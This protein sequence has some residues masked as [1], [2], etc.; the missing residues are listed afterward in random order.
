MLFRSVQGIWDEEDEFLKEAVV[1]WRILPKEV[2][3]LK[4]KVLEDNV[5]NISGSGKLYKP[6]FLEKDHLGRDLEEGSKPTKPRGKED[7]EE[8][9]K[10]LMQLKKTQSHMSIWGLLMASQK[11]RKAL[12]DALNGKEVPIETTP[13]KFLSLMGVE[14]IGR[15]HV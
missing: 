9:D 10:V 13:L 11:H 5:A 1:L 15:A 6:S 14:E 7:K 3:E 2:T 4:K 8:E 12:L